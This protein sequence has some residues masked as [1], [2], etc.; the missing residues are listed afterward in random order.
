MLSREFKKSLGMGAA[1]LRRL[2]DVQL[3]FGFGCHRILTTYL[4]CMNRGRQKN[5]RGRSNHV[6]MRLGGLLAFAKSCSGVVPLSQR[7]GCHGCLA[8]SNLSR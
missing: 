6:T 8:E 2:V 7:T 3:L 1:R 4:N 5:F